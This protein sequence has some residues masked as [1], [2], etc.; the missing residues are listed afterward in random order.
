MPRRARLKSRSG[1]YHVILRGINKQ[2]IF[3]DDEDRMVFLETVKRYQAVSNYQIFA[4]C[5]MDNHIHLLIK[6]NEEALSI[7]IKRISSSY[8]YWYNKKYERIGHLFQG[9]FKSE[10]IDSA[11]Y[12]LT[13]LRYIHQNPLK[14]GLSTDV[15][16]CK[17]TSAHEYIHGS[18]FIDVGMGLGLFSS[19]RNEAI[20]NYIHFMEEKNDDQCLE[21]EN[22]MMMKD[23][24]LREY[25]IQ[26]GIGHPSTLQQMEKEKRDA[27]LVALK[28]LEGVSLRQ[29]SRVTGISTTV[30]HRAC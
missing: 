10:N 24:Q 23:S 12:F 30:I 8:V 7:A 13:V 6:E 29:I 16:E 27:I 25:L 9:R 28:Q 2:T 5:L 4:Y 20:S 21:E 15:F 22:K 19:E 11:R 26:I 17:W 18:N 14:A 1:I 3:E